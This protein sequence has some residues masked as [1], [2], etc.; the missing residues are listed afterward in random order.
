MERDADGNITP[1]RRKTNYG[2][3]SQYEDIKDNLALE[4]LNTDTKTSKTR[5]RNYNEDGIFLN[6]TA[7]MS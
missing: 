2:R 4:F 6:L 5:L 1:K 3:Y 7:D